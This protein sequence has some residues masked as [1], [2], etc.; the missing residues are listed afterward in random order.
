MVKGRDLKT[1]LNEVFVKRKRKIKVSH[2]HRK[3]SEPFDGTG[4]FY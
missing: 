4:R 1:G 3:V 2:N